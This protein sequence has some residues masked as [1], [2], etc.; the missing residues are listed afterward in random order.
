MNK[1]KKIYLLIGPK[2]SGKSFIGGLL[3]EYFDISFLRVE[4]WVKKIKKGRS[5]DDETYLE[6]VFSCIEEGVRAG[7]VEHDCVTFESTGLTGYFDGMLISLQKDFE[8][9]TIR[10]NTDP[11]ICLSRVKSRDQSVHINISDDQVT[12][13]NQKVCEKNLKCDFAVD[14]NSRSVEALKQELQI[15]LNR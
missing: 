13:I 2:G 11:D 9:T 8:V 7:L 14:N 10:I 6:E 3:H 12:S 4:D 5:V 1:G 15:I